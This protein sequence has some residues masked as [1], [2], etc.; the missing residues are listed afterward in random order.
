M[1][2]VQ[3]LFAAQPARKFTPFF[4]AGSLYMKSADGSYD[5]I[6][7]VQ[8]FKI[9]V[10]SRQ[11]GD[12]QVI[13]RTLEVQVD[14]LT[15]GNAAWFNHFTPR[16]TDFSDEADVARAV[17]QHVGEQFSFL[18]DG[19]NMAVGRGNPSE[20]AHIWVNGADVERITLSADKFGAECRSIVRFRLPE[21]GLVIDI[22]PLSEIMPQP[23]G[24]VA[25]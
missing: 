15:N 25:A 3:Q 5:E 19:E 9:G 20:A 16:P 10:R 17:N 18:F 21:G 12:K 6:R 13:D 14:Y 22:G 4:G 24:A 7:G 1:N 11:V 2:A 8:H 23:C